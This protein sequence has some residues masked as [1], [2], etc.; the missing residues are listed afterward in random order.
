M[1]DAPPMSWHGIQEFW[2]SVI[3]VEVLFMVTWY[4]LVHLRA[5]WRRRAYDRER[6]EAA[7]EESARGGPPPG[8]A[9]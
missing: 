7:M 4:G 8:D 3:A 6:Y 2:I 9:P 1:S 5:W